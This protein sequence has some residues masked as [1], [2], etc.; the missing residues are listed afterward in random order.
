MGEEL[1]NCINEKLD[2]KAEVLFSESAARHRRQGGAGEG[3]QGG[4]RRHRTRRRD[5]QHHHRLTTGPR[6]RPTSA[7]ALQGNPD[8]NAVIGQNDEG[9]L[10]ALGAFAAA[11]KELPCLTETGGNDEVLAAVKDGKIYAS[12]ALQFAGRHGAVVRRA[13]RDD[14]R[15]D[16]RRACSSPSRRK[17]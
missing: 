1:G 6:P 8:I 7:A 16:G 2:G 4:P 14:R 12:V 13:R 11:G 10:G 5:R 3:R 9:A 15:P 17:S